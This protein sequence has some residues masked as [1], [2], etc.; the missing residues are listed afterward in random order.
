[1]AIDIVIPCLHGTDLLKEKISV[2]LL[3]VKTSREYTARIKPLLFTAMD[4]FEC[5]VL[6]EVDEKSS[7][8]PPP[9][10]RMVFALSSE[11]STVRVSMQTGPGRTEPLAE[12]VSLAKFTAYD[13]RCAG[14]TEETFGVIQQGER[15]YVDSILQT[16]CGAGDAALTHEGV[17]LRTAVREMQVLAST[18]EE[19]WASWA[20]L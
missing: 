4:P 9:I 18:E 14:A 12:S 5:D 13:I 7:E 8:P 10:V 16:M 11:T 15:T 1:M 19:H 17:V 6:D 2:I 20:D 3:R